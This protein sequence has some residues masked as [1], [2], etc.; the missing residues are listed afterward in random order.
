[1]AILNLS[2]CFEKL[3]NEYQIAEYLYFYI[4]LFNLKRSDTLTPQFDFI[5]YNQ[6]G[7]KYRNEICNEVNISKSFKDSTIMNMFEA[8]TQFIAS[9]KKDI[10]NKVEKTFLVNQLMGL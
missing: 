10:G 3:R 7:V 5:I 6:Y 4:A 2:K 8:M 9:D 1:M